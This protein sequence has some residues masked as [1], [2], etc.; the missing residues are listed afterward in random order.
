MLGK[1]H[2]H[3]SAKQRLTLM[4]EMGQARPVSMLA[5]EHVSV[6]AVVRPVSV[7]VRGSA[8]VLLAG[9]VSVVPLL[10]SVS[11]L[12]GGSVLLLGPMVAALAWPV[13]VVLLVVVGPVLR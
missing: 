4:V 1:E 3:R 11:V 12:V 13:L 6:V 9:P 7:L 5:P 2:T 10:G 8:S